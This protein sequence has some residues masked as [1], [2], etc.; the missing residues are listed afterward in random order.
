M[1]TITQRNAWPDRPPIGSGSV[2]VKYEAVCKSHAYA[3]IFTWA[4]LLQVEEGD[5]QDG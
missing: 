3:Y 2:V 4:E 5:R 1:L